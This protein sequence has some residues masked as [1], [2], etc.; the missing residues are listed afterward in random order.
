MGKNKQT[1]QLHTE[2][3]IGLLGSLPQDKLQSGYVSDDNIFKILNIEVEQVT[4]NILE[5]LEL[6]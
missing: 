4:E 3:I 6:G 1:I 2:N 5:Q